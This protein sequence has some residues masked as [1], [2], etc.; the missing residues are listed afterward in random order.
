MVM[1]HTTDIHINTIQK[2][3]SVHHSQITPAN[4][5]PANMTSRGYSNP[6][7]TIEVRVLSKLT[8]VHHSR[9]TA[10]MTSTAHSNTTEVHLLSKSTTITKNTRPC[11]T[12][13]IPLEIIKEIPEKKPPFL[14][15]KMNPY[16]K[17][18]KMERDGN[19]GFRAI[20]Y[21]T[22]GNAQKWPEVRNSMVDQFTRH[23]DFY[24]EGR[25]V[26][27]MTFINKLQGTSEKIAP[28]NYWFDN[29]EHS[30]LAADTLGVFII[31]LSHLEDDYAELYAPQWLSQ[32]GT[33][34]QRTDIPVIGM[35]YEDGH[36]DSLE[37]NW[38]DKA[39]RGLLSQ[40]STSQ[41]GLLFKNFR[42]DQIGLLH[43]KPPMM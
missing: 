19:C 35:L 4:M 3:H 13:P 40:I 15:G 39:G 18:H 10:N 38:K 42:M 37:F 20:A 16:L 30:Q 31:N 17:I 5:T 21:G 23:P 8:Y 7:T 14:K 28:I 11:D 29:F 25:E 34:L 6:K 1:V 43:L 2:P 9:T 41:D 26:G 12:T 33:E 36:W 22:F 32:P 24:L 27:A